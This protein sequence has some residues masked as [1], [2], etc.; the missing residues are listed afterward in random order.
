MTQ[1]S[2]LR[3]GIAIAGSVV[4][5]A[6]LIERAGFLPAVT[7]TVLIASLGAGT[8]TVRQA[9]VLAASVATALAVLFIG[10]LNQPFAL[11]AGF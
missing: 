1:A 9:V 7:A 11:V 2:A 8:L 6:L 4:A 3:P 10:F 5:F